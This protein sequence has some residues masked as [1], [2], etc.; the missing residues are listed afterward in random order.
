MRKFLL[1]LLFVCVFTSI[2]TAKLN[3]PSIIDNNMV[4]QQQTDAPIWGTA[5]PGAKVTVKSSWQ[6]FRGTS[7]RAD[8]NGKWQVKLSTPSAGGPY[9]VRITEK[10]ENPHRVTFKDVM[11]GEV[12]FASGQSNM[13]W[14]ISKSDNLE[15]FLAEADYPN[16][17][18][19]QAKNTAKTEPADDVEVEFDG[20]FTPCPASTIISQVRIIVADHASTKL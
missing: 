11:I 4:L 1:P 14:P 7:T 15:E 5:T 3:F 12:W 2:S 10:G 6:W 13:W 16:L 9:T 18:L 20:W 17:R 8:E 19:W